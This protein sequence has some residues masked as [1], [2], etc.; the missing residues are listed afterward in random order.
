MAPGVSLSPPPCIPGRY[1]TTLLSK[2]FPP[3]L[4]S[5]TDGFNE[6]ERTRAMGNFF[7]STP[8]HKRKAAGKEKDQFDSTASALLSA[9]ISLRH[10]KSSQ[11]LINKQNSKTPIKTPSLRFSSDREKLAVFVHFRRTRCD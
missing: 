10:K 7:P 5:Q 8:F 4:V 2:I 3:R 1:A 9:A 6:E 11:G